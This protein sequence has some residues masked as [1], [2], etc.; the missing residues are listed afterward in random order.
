MRKYNVS[1]GIPFVSGLQCGVRGGGRDVLLVVPAWHMPS[2]Q[3]RTV[4]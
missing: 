3:I 4:H 1:E 2:S